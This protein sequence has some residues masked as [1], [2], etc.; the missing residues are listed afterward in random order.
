M[1]KR[2][3]YPTVLVCVL[4]NGVSYAQRPQVASEQEQWILGEYWTVVK[5][6]DKGKTADAIKEMAKWP[7]DRIAKVQATQFQPEAALND[8]QMSKTEWKPALLRA[9]AM[10]HTEVGLDALKRQRSFPAFQFHAGIADGWFQ[11]ADNKRTIP[12][13][14]RS[15]WNVTV[16]RVFLI[17]KEFAAAEAF[18][19][20]LNA[21]IANDA[22][23][24][25]AFG[26]AK[27]SRAMR[28]IAGAPAAVG[29]KPGEPVPDAAELQRQREEL[30]SAAASLFERALALDPTLIEA[31]LRLARLAL[32]RG[33][34]AKAEKELTAIKQASQVAA[35]QYLATLW[36]GQ[37][38]ERQ[39][40]W[41]AAAE[42][43]VEAIKMQ[44]DAESA[45]VALSEVLKANGEPVQSS[46]VM[47][48]FRSRNVTSPIA[49]PVAT[50]PL[51]F[52][53][54]LEARF[55]AIIAESKAIKDK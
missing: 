50:Y 55:A 48:R 5:D 9:A 20:R 23:V 32:D 49:D 19:E 26:V 41:T 14:L 40:P 15:R 18:L 47:D 34:D 1:V 10:L 45:Y 46:G 25:F 51:G 36:L 17:N 4:F 2:L 21:K 44:P 22:G 53:T 37:I 52:D 28:L 54:L 35:H 39:K 6:Y 12:G 27:E 13:G 30:R 31:R 33:E 8:L 38:R 3:V 11:L 24:M 42:L 7:Q 29:A 16:A 43:F